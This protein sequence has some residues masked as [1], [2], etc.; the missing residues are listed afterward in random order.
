M[1]SNGV[2]KSDLAALGMTGQEDFHLHCWA[3]GPC[4]STTLL[5]RALGL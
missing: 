1:D 2:L 3:E 4:K 5:Y